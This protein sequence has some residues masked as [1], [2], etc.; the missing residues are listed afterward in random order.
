[1]RHFVRTLV[2]M[3]LLT[4]SAAATTDDTLDLDGFR[5]R[6][7]VANRSELNPTGGMTVEAWVYGNDLSGCHAIVSKD[8][9]IGWWLGLCAGEIRFYTN[10]SGTSM[11]GNGIIG[12]GEWTHVAVT[13]DGRTRRYYINGRLDFEHD[14]GTNTPLPVNTTDLGIGGDAEATGGGC[15]SRDFCEWNGS[16]AEVRL[17][18]HARS[19]SAI[20][21]DMTRQVD[22]PEAGL[23][24]AWPMEGGPAAAVGEGLDGVTRD[25]AGFGFGIPAPPPPDDPMRLRRLGTSPTVDG[26]CDSTEYGNAGWLPVWLD[27]GNVLNGVDPLQ[28]QIGATGSDL[29]VCVDT[30]SLS[31]FD[32]FF[33]YLDAAGDG[34]DSPTAGDYGFRVSQDGTAFAIEGTGTGYVQTPVSGFQG[35]KGN[36]GEFDWSAEFKIPRSL[37]PTADTEFG[38]HLLR[39]HEHDGSTT[40]H[41][42]TVSGN[43]SRPGSFHPTR[44]DDD[45]TPRPDA[46]SPAFDSL[47]TF[48][49]QPSAGEEFAVSTTARDDVDLRSISLFVGE[50][51]V[52]SGE[53]ADRT[54]VISGTDDRVS[55]CSTPFTLPAGVYYMWA[56]AEDHRGKVTNAAIKRF[57]VA[58]DGEPPELS[59]SHSPAGPAPGDTVTIEAR[60]SDPTG[61]R[62]IDLRAGTSS[63]RCDIAAGEGTCTLAVET[64]AGSFFDLGESVIHVEARTE[65]NED[66]GT[67]RRRIVL[68]GLGGDTDSDGDG[69]DDNIEARLCTSSSSADTDRDGLPDNW[70]IQGVRFADGDLIDLP[71]MGAHPCHRDVFL[72]IDYKEG[73]RPPRSGI[74]LARLAYR[75]HGIAL[76]IDERKRVPAD[77]PETYGSVRAAFQKDA[78]GD[79]WF[80]P[81]RNWTHFYAYSRDAVGN[82]SAGGRFVTIATLRGGELRRSDADLDY[83][84]I[85]ELGH[86]VGLGH[87][88]RAGSRDVIEDPEGFFYLDNRWINTNYK[89]NHRSVMSYLWGTS[90]PSCML[91]A[92]SGDFRPDFVGTLT[93]SVGDLPTLE[94]S[95][96]SGAGLD[97]AP[98]SE[99]A[100]KLAEASCPG[101]EPDAFPVIAYTCRDPDE[102]GVGSDPSRRYVM[103]SDGTRTIARMVHGGSSGG[104][105]D[106]DPPAHEP[107]IDWNCN[108]VIESTPV[109]GSL[110]GHGASVG[111]GLMSTFAF[112]GETCDGMDNDGDGN[113]D[114]GCDWDDSESL[115]NP[116]EWNNIPNPANVHWKYRNKDKCYRQ[117]EPYRLA[118]GTLGSGVEPV[119]ARPEGEPDDLCP[120]DA[121]VSDESTLPDVLPPL[122]PGTEVC[123]GIDDDGDGTVDEHCAD[124]DGDGVPD[125]LD[126]CPETPD[127]EQRDADGDGLGDACE[128]PK[129]A[130]LSLS[131]DED[132][133]SLA[134][135]GTTADTLGFNVYRET[136]EDPTPRFVGAGYP[137]TGETHF[138]ETPPKSEFY[139]YTVRVVDL[140]GEEKDEVVAELGEKPSTDDGGDGNDGDDGSNI[141]GGGGGGGG[142]AGWPWLVLSIVLVALAGRRRA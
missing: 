12:T 28:V 22:R 122:L 46:E 17:W 135:E 62:W 66:L 142:A 69:I 115:I 109:S 6:V 118:M 5:D 119:D 88:G 82:S 124:R 93:Y 131:R 87:G 29:Y 111:G 71:N 15:G 47:A 137:S 18:D 8:F 113:V 68:L 30:M 133:I 63:R 98:D 13:W 99:I 31:E 34:G 41:R 4:G 92:E 74:D 106:F 139:R 7:T 57:L 11:D 95:A 128:S 53:P 129:I 14:A 116:D 140:N 23:I 48:P 9:T 73:N 24:A 42:W 96:A 52:F 138:A 16:L 67:R 81:K 84:L 65:D 58:I 134:W 61:I 21:R 49:E 3:T 107:G 19:R 125:T 25:N 78:D 64:E 55:S 104:S 110:N 89:G 130:D 56:Q 100:T 101:S 136:G 112:P 97:E 35:A 54:C 102:S 26:I 32:S 37:M 20:R 27:D 80:P 141:S 40:R 59:I 117:P 44:V 114:E 105:W 2:V 120:D 10:G 39:I 83:R 72:Q 132:T 50:D 36:A 103:V 51:P 94:E 123:N 60:A 1:M 76:H 45:T 127:P 126:Y 77:D 33:V 91:P 43:G 108:G 38:L 79:Y 75:R 86:A 85:H 70:E 121:A 90:G